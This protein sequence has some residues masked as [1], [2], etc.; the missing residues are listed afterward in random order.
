ML[1]PK[2]WVMVKLNVFLCTTLINLNM[3]CLS[4]NLLSLWDNKKIVILRPS[5]LAHQTFGC[6]LAF[7]KTPDVEVHKTFERCW[8][9]DISESLNDTSRSSYI[10]ITFFINQCENT[11]M[12]V[13]PSCDYSLL[14]WLENT[15]RLSMFLG[16]PIHIRFLHWN[17]RVGIKFI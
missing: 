16:L 6:K 4:L 8:K 9:R 10:S 3:Y 11:A 2:N 17:F 12:I 7:F 5:I 13:P 15:T 1:F 14:P